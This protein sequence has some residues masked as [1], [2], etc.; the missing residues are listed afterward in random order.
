MSST[1]AL[2]VSSKHIICSEILS[3][4]SAMRKNSRWANMTQTPL[5]ARNDALASSLG[6][7]RAGEIPEAQNGSIRRE[8][9]LMAAFLDLKREVLSAESMSLMN[10]FSILS[11]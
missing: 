3:V 7:R 4:T 9:L 10:S 6:L 5:Y 2:A 1:S 8:V 11:G